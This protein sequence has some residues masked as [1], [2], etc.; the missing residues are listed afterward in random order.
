MKRLWPHAKP[1]LQ[2]GIVDA[3]ATVFP[4]YGLTTELSVAMAM[5]QFSE[6]CGAGI[7]TTENLNY[8]AASLVRVWPSR[9]NAARAAAYAHK[10]QQIAN[11]VYNGRMGNRTGTDDG[12]NFIGRSG[13]QITGRDG[14]RAVAQKTGLDLLANPELANDPEHFL[15]CSVA[16]FVICGCLPYALS[17][18]VTKTSAMLN[19]GHIVPASRIIGYD[20]RVAWTDRWKRALASPPAPAPEDDLTEDQIT[21][22]QTQLRTLGY[23]EVGTVDGMWG[24]KTAAGIS[25]FQHHEMLSVTGHYDDVTRAALDTAVDAGMERPVAPA[26]ANA[27]AKDV[28]ADGSVTVATAKSMNAVGRIKMW[29]GLGTVGAAGTEQLGVLDQLQDGLT[30]FHG[31]HDSFK[32]VHETIGPALE[33]PFVLVL[34]FVVLL[35]GLYYIHMSTQVIQCRVDDHQSGVHA[36]HF[37]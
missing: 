31:L 15:E 25:A 37:E 23:H 17:G 11:T 30:K 32:G 8:T 35:A 19:V 36:G 26:R 28:A 10:P 9:F 27:A 1:E 3:A 5:G 14:Y 6:E 24:S 20:Q 13:S 7:E 21:D 16:D 12:W 29:L 34:A 18:D 33:N 4:K 22:I 2:Q